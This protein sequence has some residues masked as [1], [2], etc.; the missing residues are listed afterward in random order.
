MNRQ[1]GV[2]ITGLIIVLVAAVLVLLLAFKI[3]PVYVEYNTVQRIFR[4]MAEDPALRGARRADLERAWA[5]RATVD[6]VK[7]VT[8]DN[9]EFTKEGDTWLITAEYSVKVPLFRNVA[10]CFDFKPSSEQ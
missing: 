4:N 1:K 7:A 5:A 3:V 9:L 2:T 8:G 6:D 10:A